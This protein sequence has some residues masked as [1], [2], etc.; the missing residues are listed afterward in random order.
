MGTVGDAYDSAMAESFFAS[1]ET[2]L[3]DRTNFRTRADARL[4]VFDYIEAFYNP[5]RIH[6]TLGDLSPNEY[7]AAYHET[8]TEAAVAA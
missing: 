7:E 3:L 5:L 8:L 1:L 4:A 2:E 6:S